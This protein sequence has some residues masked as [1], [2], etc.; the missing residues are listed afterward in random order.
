MLS[1]VKLFHMH[2]PQMST[3]LRSDRIT[4]FLSFLADETNPEEGN[5]LKYIT[6]YVLDNAHLFYPLS[7]NVCLLKSRKYK[8]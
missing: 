6:F 8:L 3:S 1:R 4:L 2:L 5:V 7:S